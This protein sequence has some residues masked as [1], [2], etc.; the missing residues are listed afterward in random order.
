[1]R[2]AA[3]WT[4]SLLDATNHTTPQPGDQPGVG[5]FRRSGVRQTA[6]S[7]IIRTRRITCDRAPVNRHSVSPQPCF[8]YRRGAVSTLPPPPPFAVRSRRRPLAVVRESL[9]TF[10][11]QTD[12][13]AHE[14]IRSART[15]QRPVGP[16]RRR[17]ARLLRSRSRRREGAQ[18][19]SAINDRSRPFFPP[20]HPATCRY[21]ADLRAVVR[22]NRLDRTGKNG[23]FV[24]A[25][26]PQSSDPLHLPNDATGVHRCGVDGS[27]FSPLS[28]L[29]HCNM[30]TPHS[31]VATNEQRTP[32]PG[33]GGVHPHRG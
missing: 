18:R 16:A 2:T 29:P 3:G 28:S 9:R 31:R 12:A 23:H 10:Q 21:R 26:R 22:S 32:F 4:D 24:T 30:A 20:I 17:I 13:D 25:P 11:P 33:Q 7:R 5:L 19:V 8:E 15:P 27:P 14:H 6:G 1:M